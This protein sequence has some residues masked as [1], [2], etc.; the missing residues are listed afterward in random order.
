MQSHTHH[1]YTSCILFYFHFALEVVH[2]LL[3]KKCVNIL[4]EADGRNVNKFVSATLMT[5][6]LIIAFENQKNV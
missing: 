3:I 6:K 5:F 1:I 2:F 4:E